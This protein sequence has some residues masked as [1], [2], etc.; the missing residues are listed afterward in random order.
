MG[1]S[2][3]EDVQSVTPPSYAVRQRQ[4][5]SLVTYN[6]EDADFLLIIVAVAVIVAAR[7]HWKRNSQ[8]FPIISLSIQEMQLRTAI[9]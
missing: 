8:I 2:Y 6:L 3:L 4:C 5:T 9:S 1:D 7:A